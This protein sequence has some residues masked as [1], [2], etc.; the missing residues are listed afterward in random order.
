MRHPETK[1]YLQASAACTRL[2]KKELRRKPSYTVRKCSTKIIT[3]NETITS[4]G[5]ENIENLGQNYAREKNAAAETPPLPRRASRLG[6]PRPLNLPHRTISPAFFHS[7]PHL[8]KLPH[9]PLNPNSHSR[10]Q[11]HQQP[12]HPRPP[13]PPDHPRLTIAIASQNN[14][15]HS[16][17]PPDLEIQPGKRKCCR[18]YEC[19]VNPGRGDQNSCNLQCGAGVTEQNEA[20]P[21]SEDCGTSRPMVRGDG[22]RDRGDGDG[23]ASSDR[24]HDNE[25]FHDRS[26]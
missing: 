15:P 18:V 7:C 16:S 13:T 2:R 8:S 5:C 17:T 12:L 14:P 22:V 23:E 4:I 21:S 19:D 11:Q 26:A 6:K 25:V 3:R 1:I 24:F 9:S 20:L 10:Y